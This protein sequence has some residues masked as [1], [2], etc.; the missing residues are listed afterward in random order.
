MTETP[1][2]GPN[3]FSLDRGGRCVLLFVERDG[4]AAAA[5]S[6]ALSCFE[7]MTWPQGWGAFVIEASDRPDLVCWFGIRQTPALIVIRDR[8][9]LAIE[10]EC[11][12]EACA[13]VMAL[14]GG[15]DAELAFD[16]DGVF[17]GLRRSCRN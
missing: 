14:T 12:P 6:D 15:R 2:T 9:I 4:A 11:S 8:S 7:S 17:T 13:R 10:H 5:S 1:S 3:P 16:V